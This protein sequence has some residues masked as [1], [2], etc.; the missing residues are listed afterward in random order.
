MRQFF[1]CLLVLE[2]LFI[3]VAT[4]SAEPAVYT[5]N[6]EA[7]SLLRFN[8]TLS[9]S[10]AAFDFLQLPDDSFAGAFEDS[11]LLLN[12]SRS[13]IPGYKTFK[14]QMLTSTFGP[15]IQSVGMS[16]RS[17]NESALQIRVLLR[18]SQK[19][20]TTDQ[21]GGLVSVQYGMICKLKSK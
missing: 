17:N 1:I 13:N 15:H 3:C 6:T 8:L 7:H 20:Y 18:V 10:K 5:C 11:N 4:A 19:T 2:S 14:G 21:D 9:E 16:M 12:V